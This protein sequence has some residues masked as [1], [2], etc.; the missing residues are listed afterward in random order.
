M[1]ETD[2]HF[3][4]GAEINSTANELSG[5]LTATNEEKYPRLK[6]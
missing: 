3:F 2:G 6:E 1:L 4:L 5:W